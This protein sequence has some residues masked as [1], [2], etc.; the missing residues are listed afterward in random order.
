MTPAEYRAHFA[1][2]VVRGQVALE[3]GEAPRLAS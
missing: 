2:F 1:P 3:S